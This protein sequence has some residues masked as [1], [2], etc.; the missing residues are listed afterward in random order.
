MSDL[1]RRGPPLREVSAVGRVV[2]A[3][4]HDGERTR[5]TKNSARYEHTL[6]HDLWVSFEAFLP[7]DERRA[8][9]C[10]VRIIKRPLKLRVVFPARTPHERTIAERTRLA[11]HITRRNPRIFIDIRQLIPLLVVR[12]R[13]L[14]F[15]NPKHLSERCGILTP[16]CTQ[17]LP[18]R[19]YTGVDPAHPPQSQ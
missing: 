9:R 15:P 4:R 14:P 5:P 1:A 10:P 17:P 3:D 19:T 18:P 6:A 12:F 8:P 11:A 13:K 2:T 16:L 7:P